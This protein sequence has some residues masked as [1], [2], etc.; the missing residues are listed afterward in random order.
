M[1]HKLKLSPYTKEIACLVGLAKNL[2]VSLEIGLMKTLKSLIFEE[3]IYV[4][5]SNTCWA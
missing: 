2:L 5:T 4:Y 1:F 3:Y